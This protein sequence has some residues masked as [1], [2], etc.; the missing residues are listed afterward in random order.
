MQVRPG[1]SLSPCQANSNLTECIPGHCMERCKERR[2]ERRSAARCGSSAEMVRAL[3]GLGRGSY[4]LLTAPCSTLQHPAKFTVSFEFCGIFCRA[5]REIP[6]TN[7]L[8]RHWDNCHRYSTITGGMDWQGTIEPRP[9]KQAGSNYLENLP[10]EDGKQTP[11]NL[12]STGWEAN[13]EEDSRRLRR[14]QGTGTWNKLPLGLRAV[15]YTAGDS[16]SFGIQR[17]GSR[18]QCKRIVCLL[19][20]LIAVGRKKLDKRELNC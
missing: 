8:N 14:M 6:N 15:G 16:S 12:E 13:C 5:F 7:R 10:W 1:N 4:S 17:E 19:W 11:G 2:E 3:Q 20:I 18:S 9:G